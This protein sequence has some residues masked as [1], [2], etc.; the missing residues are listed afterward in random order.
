MWFHQYDVHMRR[1]LQ[2]NSNWN[3]KQLKRKYPELKALIHLHLTITQ[4]RDF[5]SEGDNKRKTGIQTFLLLRQPTALFQFFFSLIEQLFLSCFSLQWHHSLLFSVSGVPRKNQEERLFHKALQNQ[6]KQKGCAAL[7][8][9]LASNSHSQRDRNMS[10]M[11]DFKSVSN[12]K[13]Q[14]EESPNPNRNR[15]VAGPPT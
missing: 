12:T 7:L 8:G 9:S 14:A 11:K 15:K 13:Y 2:R 6:R 3:T 4:Q 1:L 5:F 10:F